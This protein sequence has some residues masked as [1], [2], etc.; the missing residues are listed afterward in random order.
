MGQALLTPYGSTYPLGG[1][2]GGREGGA[3]TGV[4]ERLMVELQNEI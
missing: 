3:G 1:V 4:G 2:D